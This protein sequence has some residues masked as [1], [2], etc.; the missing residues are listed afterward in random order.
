L[1]GK[2]ANNSSV[3]TDNWLDFFLCMVVINR[4]TMIVSVV[5]EYY[6][7]SIV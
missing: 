4:L 1:R 7:V 5:G 6:Q 3:P 2:I